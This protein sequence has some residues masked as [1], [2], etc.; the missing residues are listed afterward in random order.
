M[1]KVFENRY[2]YL[3]LAT[4]CLGLTS[5]SSN[6]LAFNIAQVCMGS[7][8]FNHTNQTRSMGIP[9]DYTPY[10]VSLINW[11][12]ALGTAISTL[13]FSEAYVR[14]GAKWPFLIAGLLSV[15]ATALMPL[16][17]EFH[18]YALLAFR[19]LQGI[20]Y[21]ADFAAVGSLCSSWASLKQNGLFLGVLT[22]YSPLSSALTN[23]IGGMICKSSYGWPM[24][25]YVHAIS[26]FVVFV[27]WFLVY[28][29]KPQDS[30]KVSPIELEKIQRNK[31]RDQING[32]KKIPYK[33][34]LTDVR[35][36]SIWFSAFAEIFSTNF[37]AVYSPYY[38]KNV[39]QY[40]AEETGNFSAL[41]RLVQ[42]PVRLICGEMSD[43]I[44]F[45]SENLKLIVFNTITVGGAGIAY[46]LVGFM[47]ID[48]AILPIIGFCV[49]N[50][51]TGAA[52]GAFYKAA[53]LYSRQ[54]SHFVIATC[55]FLK[56]IALF[57]GPAL[58]AVFVHD[59]GSQSQWR[60]VFLITAAFL[61]MATI[62]FCI[63]STS[64]AAVYTEEYFVEKK[65]TAIYVMEN[66]VKKGQEWST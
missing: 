45:L 7:E 47:P 32:T 42:I 55:Q 56:C 40:S 33:S 59:A 8:Y 17:A 29:D 14:L 43:R 39:L 65:K 4:G 25:F 1:T 21:A 58:V 51:S 61:F 5:I 49:V 22:S 15:F 6:M 9:L 3:I 64:E 12:V 19:F 44:T 53:V 2:R 66:G 62:V 46:A 30:R 28:C 24:V 26:G 63:F 18:F 10:E 35:I 41:S 50:I 57:L 54:Y 31:N 37:L 38:I 11:A 13:P 20:S 23:S 60:V 16:A 27:L 34:L 48:V 52:S 36:W